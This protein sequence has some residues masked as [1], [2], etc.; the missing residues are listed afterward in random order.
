MAFITAG[1]AN[2]PPAGS[3]SKYLRARFVAAVPAAPLY[4]IGKG[5]GVIKDSFQE[6]K[7]LVLLALVGGPSVLVISLDSSQ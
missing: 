5:Q 4:L 6:Q 7:T 2:A 1:D 3:A